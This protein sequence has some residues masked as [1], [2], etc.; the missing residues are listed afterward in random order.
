MQCMKTISLRKKS[1]KSF[2]TKTIEILFEI[3]IERNM[4]FNAL[5]NAGEHESILLNNY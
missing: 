1:S 5:L 4:E 2:N 3:N